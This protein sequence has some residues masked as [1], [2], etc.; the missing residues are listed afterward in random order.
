MQ[1]TTTTTQTPASRHGIEDAQ[2]FANE[3]TQEELLAA[4]EPGQ[5]GADEGLLSALGTEMVARLF[6]VD[7]GT[8][9]FTA[10][11]REYNLA[12]IREARRLS[13]GDL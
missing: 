10:A 2:T 3:S 1:T 13:S 9:A 11:C 8:E 5:Y 4:I 6:G 7:A 12:W